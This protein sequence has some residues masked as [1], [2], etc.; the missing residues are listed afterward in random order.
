MPGRTEDPTRTKSSVV[1]WVVVLVC[2]AAVVLTLAFGAAYTGIESA[3]RTAALAN[4]RQIESV[5]LLAEKSAEEEGL[6]S[7]VAGT[8]KM[9]K[10]YDETSWS[11]LH[12][13]ER[14]LLDYM[15]D[16]FG[17]NRDFDFAVSRYRDA[18][19]QHTYIYFFPVRGKN[20]LSS[21]KYYL[22]LDGNL[23]E[24]RG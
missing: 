2:V 7:P 9:L 17:P 15:L 18:A 21:D 13:Y 20:N 3:R 19:G 5:L 8:E 1:L 12:A 10:S 23:V 16:F 14:F 6:P 11:E 22:M 24:Q 4:L